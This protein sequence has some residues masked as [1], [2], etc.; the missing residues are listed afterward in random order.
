MAEL[1][2]APPT[3]RSRASASWAVA[4]F[5]LIAV[6][7]LYYVKWSPLLQ[8]AFVAAAHHSIGPSIVT[9]TAAAAAAP[10]VAAAWNYAVAYVGDVWQAMVVGLLLGAGVQALLPPQWLQRALGRAG[11][12]SV[13]LAG[14]AAIPMMMCTCCSAP[15]AVGLSE[16]RVAP[17]AAI[18]FWL[19]NPL[20]NPATVVFIGFVLGWRWAVV[21]IVA[22]AALVLAAGL[23][24]NRRARPASAAPASPPAQLLPEPSDPGVWR[25]WVAILGRLTV[26][27]IPEWL[28][29]VLLLG[30][31]R[32]W[33]FPAMTP[34]I[35]AALWLLPAMAVAGTLF[36]IPTAGE[37]PILQVLAGYGLG[38][39]PFG[40]LLL[41]LPAISLPS[42]VMVGR[43][44]ALGWRVLLL[45]A[46]LVAVLATGTGLLAAAL[47]L[48]T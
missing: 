4:G 19:A 14:A 8:K 40:A 31:A 23:L 28:V 35:G 37:V 32:A 20:L 12:G 9:G 45:T 38:A 22:G 41:A 42:M 18:A 47:G 17:G 36:V 11:M 1:Q 30:A 24:A 25:R 16:R 44:G 2:T 39:A 33:M 6:A 13:G 48:P 26:G 21:R 27:V 15:L 46:L 7:G 3:R 29:I 5:T 34:Q 10:S 43:G